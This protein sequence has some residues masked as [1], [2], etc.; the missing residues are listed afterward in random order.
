[1]SSDQI[2]CLDRGFSFR[3]LNSVKYLPEENFGSFCERKGFDMKEFYFKCE[4]G[5][6]RSFDEL[7]SEVLEGMV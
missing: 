5:M 6:R 4:E 2:Q 3:F 1:M 7:R